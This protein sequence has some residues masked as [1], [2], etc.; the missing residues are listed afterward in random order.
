[1]SQLGNKFT[2]PHNEIS[3]ISGDRLYLVMDHLLT[4]DWLRGAKFVQPRFQFN[5]VTPVLPY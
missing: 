5:A 1:M 3:V 4:S 2:F